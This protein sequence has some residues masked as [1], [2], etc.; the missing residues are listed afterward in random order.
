M[1]L[2]IYNNKVKITWRRKN[3][4]SICFEWSPRGDLV[5]AIIA[6]TT[7]I[8]T[9]HFLSLNPWQKDTC[10]ESL[11]YSSI[12]GI[13][14]SL[15]EPVSIA[16]LSSSECGAEDGRSSAALVVVTLCRWS[17]YSMYLSKHLPGNRNVLHKHNRKKCCTAHPQNSSIGAKNIHVMHCNHIGQLSISNPL[18]CAGNEVTD[19]A[20]HP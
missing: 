1:R 14:K 7:L 4:Y 12:F 2:H 6:I 19:S 16:G 20:H 13:S 9:R 10:F 18:R 3:H 15:F 8:V 5:V 17:V 11:H